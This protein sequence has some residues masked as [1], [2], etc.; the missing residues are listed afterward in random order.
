MRTLVPMLGISSS[1]SS[2]M[3]LMVLASVAG[4]VQLKALFSS[5][6]LALPSINTEPSLCGFTSSASVGDIEVVKSPTISSRMSSTVTS[7]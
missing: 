4:S 6:T 2:S 3:P 7:P 1:S 5:R